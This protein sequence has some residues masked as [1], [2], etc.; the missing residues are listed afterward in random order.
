M[1]ASDE[2]TI[3]HHARG[4]GGRYV[5]EIAGEEHTGHLDW[6]PAGEGVRVATHTIVPPEIGG[7]GIAA[8]LVKRLIADAREHGFK[9]VPQCS[10]VARKFDKNPDWADLRA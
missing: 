1:S 8:Q 6:E 4:H 10:Y 9:I 3:T 7:R 5:A 2:T